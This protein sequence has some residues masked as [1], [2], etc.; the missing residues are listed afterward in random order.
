MAG[1]IVAQRLVILKKRDKEV[2]SVVCK[3]IFIGTQETIKAVVVSQQLR[4]IK[5]LPHAE[6]PGPDV[7]S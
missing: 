6:P 7:D 1:E 3:Y 5:D 4:V 2:V